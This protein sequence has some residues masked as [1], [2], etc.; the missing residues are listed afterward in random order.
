MRMQKWLVGC[1]LPVKVKMD[2]AIRSGFGLNSKQSVLV[3]SE[4]TNVVIIVHN[5]NYTP[6]VGSA[7]ARRLINCDNIR[8]FSDF[9]LLNDMT[10]CSS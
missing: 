1:H 5:T 7:V 9:N 10:H 2:E 3:V 6:E 4:Y 8:F